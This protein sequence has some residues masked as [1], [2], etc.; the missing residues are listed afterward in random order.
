MRVKVADSLGL[1]LDTRPEGC[2][3]R[4]ENLSDKALAKAVDEQYDG[5]LKAF[6]AD[7]QGM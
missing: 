2:Y 1:A 4:F 7:G 5:G 6:I 3:G